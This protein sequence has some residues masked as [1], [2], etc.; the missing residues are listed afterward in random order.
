[1]DDESNSRGHAINS[2]HVI[3]GLASY[4]GGPSYSVPRLCLALE[5]VGA[6]V[7][8][9]SVSEGA[10][11]PSRIRAEMHPHTFAQVPIMSGL[12][13]ST[14]LRDALTKQAAHLDVIHNHGLWL[15]PNVYA[16]RAA[17]RSGKPLVVTPRGMLATQALKFSS[18]KKALFW[19]LLQRDAFATAAVWHATSAEEAKDIRAFGI[20]APLAL[21]PNGVDISDARATHNEANS[22]RRLLF[23]SRLHPKKGLPD[24][25]SAWS[26]LAQERPDWDLVIAGPDEAGHRSELEDQINRLGAPRIQ[27][28]GEVLGDE[29]SAL[30]ATSDLFVLPTQNE[31]FGIAVAEALAAGVPAIVTRGAPW[32]RLQT[33]RCGWWIDHG[34]EP[35]AGA[36]REATALPPVARLEMGMRGRAWMA[37]DFGWDAIASDMLA[38]YRWISGRGERPT[39]VLEI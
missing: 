28:M 4:N 29:K 8:L 9:L 11:V 26:R 6:K 37:R 22:R 5:R 17:A 18:K 34:V 33:E 30:L 39:C 24:L 27:F 25:V 15:M 7:S 10:N 21:I 3:A 13:F 38:L 2:L 31:N 1:M 16:G 35:L 23:L 14:G 32:A 12:R 20:R 19:A 36:L